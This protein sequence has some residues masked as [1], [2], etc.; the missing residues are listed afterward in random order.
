MPNFGYLAPTI[1]TTTMTSTVNSTT[2]TTLTN[3]G[4]HYPVSR[5]LDL[6]EISVRQRF[7]GSR[8]LMNASIVYPGNANIQFWGI[9]GTLQLKRSADFIDLVYNS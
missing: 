1:L 9:F 2:T 5:L 4:T 7:D 8:R 3:T 6:D